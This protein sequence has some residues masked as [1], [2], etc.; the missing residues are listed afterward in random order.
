[1][2]IPDRFFIA[3]FNVKFRLKIRGKFNILLYLYKS[4]FNITTDMRSQV[5]TL[6]HVYLAMFPRT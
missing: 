6:L 4:F 3:H 2:T 5:S 1:M